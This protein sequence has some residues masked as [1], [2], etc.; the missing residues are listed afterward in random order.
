MTITS[1]AAGAIRRR[2]PPF[3]IKKLNKKQKY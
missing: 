2:F 1:A 3:Y